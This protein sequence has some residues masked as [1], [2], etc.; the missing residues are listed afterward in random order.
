MTGPVADGLQAHIL[1][2][3]N[4]GLITYDM[5]IYYTVDR[6]GLQAATLSRTSAAGLLKLALA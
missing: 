4:V 3:A 5:S 1:Q 6:A 2:K